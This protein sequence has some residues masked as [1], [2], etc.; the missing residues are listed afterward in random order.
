MDNPELPQIRISDFNEIK[1]NIYLLKESRVDIDTPIYKYLD[2]S[3]LA[4]IMT[5]G[6]FLIKCRKSYSDR[7]EGGEIGN[8]FAE[9]LL[10][11]GQKP[12]K[13]DLKRWED[14]KTLRI[15]SGNIPTACFTLETGELY[16][17]WKSYTSEYTGVR[18]KTTLGQLIE[19]LDLK[20]WMVY[21]G[22]MHYSSVEC[23]ALPGISKYIFTKNYC[24]YPEKEFRIY[25]IPQKE[26]PAE[27][28][29]TNKPHFIKINGEQAINEIRL[30]PFI[31]QKFRGEYLKTLKKAFPMLSNRIYHSSILEKS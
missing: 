19:N 4:D 29:D 23:G 27:W 14:L 24:Y 11:V 13:A 17:M 22:A 21:T 9:C 15:R 25:L 26:W 10:P 30:S 16:A 5:G 1:P 8:P 20:D 31:P 3:A 18:I 28:E 6:S 7:H 2:L 12:T